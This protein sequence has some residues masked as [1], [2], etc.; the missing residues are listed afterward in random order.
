MEQPPAMED[1]DPIS[2][3]QLKFTGAVSKAMSK[4]LAPLFANRDQ[5]RTRP[6][7]YNGKNDGSI[8]DWLPLMRREVNQNRQSMGDY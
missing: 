7:I 1:D 6:T 8:D 5:T 3:E 4:E 2:H